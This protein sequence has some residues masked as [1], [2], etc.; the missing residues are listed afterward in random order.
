M[1]QFVKENDDRKRDKKR[2]G[3]AQN[4]MAEGI[5]SVKNKFHLFPAETLLR[6]RVVPPAFPQPKQLQAPTMPVIRSSAT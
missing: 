4:H 6:P 3:F 5:Y 1:T 2:K